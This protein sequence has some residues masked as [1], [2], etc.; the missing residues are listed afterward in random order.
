MFSPANRETGQRY[1]IPAKMMNVSTFDSAGSRSAGDTGWVYRQLSGV[2]ISNDA[3]ILRYIVHG[4]GKY[5]DRDFMWTRG[6]SSHQRR[7]TL[8]V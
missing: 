6:P 2:Q 7:V 5:V 8:T 3:F 1:V 4:D